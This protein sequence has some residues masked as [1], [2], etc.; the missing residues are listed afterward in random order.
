MRALWRRNQ[1]SRVCG[2]HG[3]TDLTGAV[4]D[5][6]AGGVAYPRSL[7]QGAPRPAHIPSYMPPLPEPHTYSHTKVGRTTA[8][9]G[10]SID[11][12]PWLYARPDEGGEA[13]DQQERQP[14]AATYRIATCARTVVASGCGFV[15]CLLP[16]T[17]LSLLFRSKTHWPLFTPRVVQARP[18]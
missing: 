11:V 7:Q 12:T 3:G 6:S 1:R 15:S 2:R 16:C 4:T 17:V 14:Q 9:R 8:Q 5:T 18:V 10:W 13:E